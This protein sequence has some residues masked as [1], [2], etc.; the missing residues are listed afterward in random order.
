MLIE[1]DIGR[2]QDVLN[3]WFGPLENN[4]SFPKDR[5]SLWFVKSDQTDR[6]I[7]QRF[8]NDLDRAAAGDYDSWKKSP[9][10]RLALVILMDQMSRNIHRGTPRAFATDKDALKLALEAVETG[11]DKKLFLIERAFLYMPLEHSEDSEIQELSIQKF[12]ELVQEAPEHCKSAY[13][14]FL[15]YA[16]AHK[17]VI[18]RFGRYPHRNEILGRQSTSEEIEFLKQPGSGF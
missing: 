17:R 13:E 14:T 10:G 1:A 6:E 7:E 8:S 9:R 15:S 18:D 5:A 16:E 11:E 4:D 3:Y 12:S 2:G